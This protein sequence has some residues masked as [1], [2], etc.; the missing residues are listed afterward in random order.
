MNP[1]LHNRNKTVLILLKQASEPTAKQVVGRFPLVAARHSS[2]RLRERANLRELKNA[3]PCTLVI[4][5][6]AGGDGDG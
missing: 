6:E 5:H 4:S 1:C 3:E 2:E